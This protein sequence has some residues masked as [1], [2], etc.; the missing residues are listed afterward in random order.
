MKAALPDPA[1]DPHRFFNVM[2]G[3]DCLSDIDIQL[4]CIDLLDS[5]R[6]LLV[7]ECCIDFA[8][9]IL[10]VLS[11]IGGYKEEDNEAWGRGPVKMAQKRKCSCQDLHP[12]LPGLTSL[13]VKDVTT[14]PPESH[15]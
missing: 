9:P 2:T 5:F 15:L 13:A 8:V 10:R 6:S 11:F 3:V 4:F 14:T 1:R 12:C 7:A